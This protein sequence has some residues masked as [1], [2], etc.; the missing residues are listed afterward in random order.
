MLEENPDTKTRGHHSIS[1]R[2]IMVYG[3]LAAASAIIL[4][5]ERAFAAVDSFISAE[6]SLSFYNLHTDEELTSVY[7]REGKYQSA[8]LRD[9]NH[10]LRDYRTGDVKKIDPTLLDLLHT[11]HNKV[12]ASEPFHIISGYRS[13]KTNA[14]LVRKSWGVARNSQHLLGRAVDIRL[15]ECGLDCLHKAAVDLRAGGVGYYPASDFI[16]VDV[17]RVRYW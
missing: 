8:A 16:H 5:H 14:M 4:P 2:G 3:M 13:P 7:W 11:L 1:R 6:R 9:I 10:I 12:G 15:P 17:G